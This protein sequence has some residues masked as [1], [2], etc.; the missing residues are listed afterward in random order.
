MRL[1][2]DGQPTVLRWDAQGALIHESRPFACGAFGRRARFF[3][4]SPAE[5]FC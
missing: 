1:Q 4:L 5:N 2:A 3:F